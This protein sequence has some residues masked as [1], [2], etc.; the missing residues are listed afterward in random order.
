MH[1]SGEQQD[2]MISWFEVKLFIDIRRT[3][4]GSRYDG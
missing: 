1:T 2:D 4:L 3:K